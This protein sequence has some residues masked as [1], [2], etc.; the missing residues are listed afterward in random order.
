[1]TGAFVAA[2]AVALLAILALVL[3]TRRATARVAAEHSRVEQLDIQLAETDRARA[4]AAERADGAAQCAANAE[5]RLVA[6][7]TL[8]DLERLRLEREWAEVAGMPAPLPE[9]WDGTIGAALAVELEIIREVMGV[10][11]RIESPSAAKLDDP[12][13]AVTGF[14]LTAEV[15][16]SLAR[17]GDEIAVSFG[18]DGLVT[19]DVATHGTGPGPNLARP[20]AAAFALGGE[21]TLLP[22]DGGLQARLRLPGP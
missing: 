18:V 19:I 9:P 13:T 15:V 20:M 12:I 14:R 11:G 2:V 3:T 16:R 5:N 17:V 1:V 22:T 10:P 7:G 21:L 6:A 4:L 8:W